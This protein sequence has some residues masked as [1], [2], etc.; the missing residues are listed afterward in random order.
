MICEKNA[1]IQEEEIIQDDNLSADESASESEVFDVGSTNHL[2]QALRF[3]QPSISRAE[4]IDEPLKHRENSNLP[5][6]HQICKSLESLTHHVRDSSLNGTATK[7]FAAPKPPDQ[8]K[9]QNQVK[10]EVNY[11]KVLI[12]KI[13][14]FF[15]RNILALQ[16]TTKLLLQILEFLILKMIRFLINGIIIMNMKITVIK[17]L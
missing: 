9:N 5:N 17:N 1:E 10:Q 6:S 11:L 15:F 2:N 16:K 4:S 13:Q 7:K 12:L 3:S 14:N 8:Q